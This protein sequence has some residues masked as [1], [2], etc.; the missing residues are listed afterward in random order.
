M[1]KKVKIALGLVAFYFLF[2]AAWQVGT[3]VL[4]NVEL[5]DDMQDIVSQPAVH[6]GLASGP[7][8][9]DLRQTVMRKAERYNI[10]LSPDQ[11]IVAHYGYDAAAT[12]Y[13]EANYSVP[14]YLPHFQFSMYF[15]PSTAH[16]RPDS[17]MA[18]SSS[19]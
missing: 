7:S 19:Q 15:N 13:L 16:K 10:A 2:S 1:I 3:C 8:D 4:G 18:D 6:I 14:I 5:K 9:D 17:A 11:V 12:I